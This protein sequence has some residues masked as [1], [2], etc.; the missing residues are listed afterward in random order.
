MGN[1]YEIP[2]FKLGVLPAAADLS[3]NQFQAVKVVSSSGTKVNIPSA[4]GDDIIGILQNAPE[5]NE[6][7]EVMVTGV[8]KAKLGDTVAIGDKL[9]I[10]ASG[11]LVPVGAGQVVARSLAV[12]AVNEIVSVLLLRD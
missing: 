5:S 1:A 7:A 9:Q 2:G 10:D 4:S 11:R 8:S 12:G 6:A 3:A